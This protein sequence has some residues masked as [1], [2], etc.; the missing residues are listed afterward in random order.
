M[1]AKIDETDACVIVQ[2]KSEIKKIFT[3]VFITMIRQAFFRTTTA[4]INN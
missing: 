4:L 3:S 2:L 1:V